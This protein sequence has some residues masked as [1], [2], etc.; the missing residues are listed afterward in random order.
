[1]S[2]TKPSREV[3]LDFI[4]NHALFSGL[5]GDGLIRIL[6]AGTD[7]TISKNECI[8]KE[9][10]SGDSFYLILQGLL[11][12][13]KEV[14]TNDGV[15]SERIALLE[16]GETFGEMAIIDSM[17]RSAT[18]RAMTDS[19]TLQFNQDIFNKL[20]DE[21]PKTYSRIIQNLAKQVSYK[22]RMVDIHFAI[23]LFSD[24]R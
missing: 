13:I 10:D 6:S 22:L 9:G 1:M 20:G 8:V 24:K 15:R 7:R 23:A 4:R 14:P 16:R 19:F 12:V 17:P 3:T 2:D 18:V 21:D 5:D 11:E